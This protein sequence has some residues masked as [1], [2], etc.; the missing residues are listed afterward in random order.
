M[1]NVAV[2]C[3]LCGAGGLVL[4]VDCCCLFFVVLVLVVMRFVRC[5]SCFAVCVLRLLCCLYVVD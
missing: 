1:C 3:A 5:A 2:C 4:F